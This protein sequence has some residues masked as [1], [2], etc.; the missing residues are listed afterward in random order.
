MVR[1]ITDAILNL[2]PEEPRQLTWSELEDL[3][4]RA[5]DRAVVKVFNRIS[6]GDLAKLRLDM[7]HLREWRETCET[8]RNN[9]YRA[10]IGAIAT[11]VI[12]LLILGAKQFFH[13]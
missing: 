2:K 10:V 9:S 7:I 8:V 1:D 11:G 13:S 4:E 3:T 6:D 12:A 5:A